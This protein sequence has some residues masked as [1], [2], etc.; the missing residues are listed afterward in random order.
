[1]VVVKLLFSLWYTPAMDSSKKWYQ[2]TWAAI[3]FLFLF[4][5]VGLYLMWKYTSWPKVAK[6]VITGFFG[7]MV[8]GSAMGGNTKTAST[9]VQP[10]QATQQEETQAT[11]EPTQET[12]KVTT[13]PT[14]AQ[15][16]QVVKPTTPPVSN[17]TVSQKN[18]LRK[19]QSYLAYTAFSHDGLVAQLEY[20]KFSHEDAVYGADNVGANWNEQAAK[21]A[22]SYMDMQGYSRD[23]LIEQ[24]KY[25][26]FTQ[27]QA[28]YG[29][30]AV[31]L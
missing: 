29:A 17:T 30:N 13:A 21:K 14:V 18:A 11:V 25:E 28:E 7:L 12:V 1:M 15:T 24:L 31:G 2:K 26:K 27:E 8:L 22:K 6:W 4:F 3:L 19:A 20:E 23:G 16:K 9:T 5:P 10:T